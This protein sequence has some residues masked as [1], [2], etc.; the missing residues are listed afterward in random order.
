MIE[1]TCALIV[2]Q[3][4]RVLAAQRGILK[5][6]AG[7]WEFPGGK[8]EP[9]ETTE[10]C[11]L[12][13]IRE[14]LDVQVRVHKALPVVVHHYAR[15]TIKLLPFICSLEEG[16]ITLREHTAARWLLPEELPALD[17]APADLPVLESYL[18]LL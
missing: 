4:G 10:Q 17:W 6:L 16:T 2:D 5:E 1:V 12:R 3:Q 13:E 18:R 9:G 7:K 11:L 15:G 8:I 14:E